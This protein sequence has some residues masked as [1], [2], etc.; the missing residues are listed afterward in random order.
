M[1]QPHFS[2]TESVKNFGQK[3]VSDKSK[4]AADP[5][6]TWIRPPAS[7]LLTPYPGR[8][9]FYA[10]LAGVTVL[11][12]LALLSR[13]VSPDFTVLIGLLAGLSGLVV[14]DILNRRRWEYDIAHKIKTMTEGHDR[15]V[16]EVARN[17]NQIAALK[18]GLAEAAAAV[19]MQGRRLPASTSVEARMLETIVRRLSLLGEETR[20]SEKTQ[21]EDHKVFALEIA[22]PPEKAPPATALDEAI[23]PDL[24]KLGNGIVTELIHKAVQ[25]DRLDAFLQPVVSLPQR[26]VRM[27][28]IF[29][30]LPAGGG[31]YLSPS[32][33]LDIA[34]HESMLPALDNLILLR[35]LQMLRD[36]RFA[37]PETAFILNVSG[38]TLND[39][40]FMNDLV[41]FLSQNRDM[42]ARLVFELPQAELETV[43]ATIAP[44]LDGLTKLGCRFSMDRVRRRHINVEKLR[45]RHIR[46]IKMEADWLI[47]EADI[48]GGIG[49]ILGLKKELAEAGI[50]IVVEKI[51][52][53]ATLRALLDFD[54]AYGQG[55]LFGKP[56]YHHAFGGAKAA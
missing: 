18:A 52:T 19:E 21:T 22:P 15:L 10:G 36:K 35:C 41:A 26:R 29:A 1:S 44:L 7:E 45:A 42:A 31:S 55:Y 54:I 16:R 34:R 11:G 40:G 3:P 8:S 2:T 46:F 12:G 49:R 47:K 30:R 24:N 13:Y 17:R 43:D 50:D 51:E 27:Y 53:E 14:Y 48:R 32:R 37:D 23:T 33:Y 5:T 4:R 9:R 25:D 28:E 39:S 6:L 20:P 56:D 38:V